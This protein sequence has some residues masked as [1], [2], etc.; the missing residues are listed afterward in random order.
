[1][2]SMK[3]RQYSVRQSVSTRNLVIQSFHQLETDVA[4]GHIGKCEL[5]SSAMRGVLSL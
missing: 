5:I 1:M 4:C 2:C 3:Q